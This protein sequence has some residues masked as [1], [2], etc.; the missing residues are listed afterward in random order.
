MDVSVDIANIFNTR[1]A[2]HTMNE[3]N[4]EFDISINWYVFNIVYIFVLFNF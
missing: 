3:Q 4:T 2:L 1:I